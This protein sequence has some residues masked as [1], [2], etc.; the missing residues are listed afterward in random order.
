M[1]CAVYRDSRDASSVRRQRAMVGSAAAVAPA[2]AHPPASGENGV[3]SGSH[4]SPPS[5]DEED[6]PK[7]AAAWPSH[8]QRFKFLS[9]RFND[10][11]KDTVSLKSQV[12]R[13]A[14]KQNE[15]HAHMAQH[16][17]DVQRND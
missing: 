1:E 3:V 17:K 9:A 13:R 8:L 15:H 12:E 6:L 16:M 7:T 10:L 14:L 11:Q 2:P 4:A 5:S